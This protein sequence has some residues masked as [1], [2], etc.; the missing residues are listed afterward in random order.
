MLES[1][2][3]DSS[4]PWPD[5]SQSESRWPDCCLLSRR[6]AQRELSSR[7]RSTSACPRGPASSGSAPRPEVSPSRCSSASS[8][9]REASRAPPARP[10]IRR[11]PRTASTRRCRSSRVA[12]VPSRRGGARSSRRC[13]RWASVEASTRRGC[14]SPRRRRSAIWSGCSRDGGRCTRRGRPEPSSRC[15]RGGHGSRR[16]CGETSTLWQARAPSS[17]ADRD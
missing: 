9:T 8:R 2:D 6:P 14:A 13:V 16:G 1:A 3:A 10:A 12:W 5:C 11:L 15:P 7:Q 17:V 4:R